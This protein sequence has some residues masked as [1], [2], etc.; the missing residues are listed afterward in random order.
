M[1]DRLFDI[2]DIKDETEACASPSLTFVDLGL[3]SGTLW[4]ATDVEEPVMVGCTLPSYQQAQELIDCC[5]FRVGTYPDGTRVMCILG[6]SGHSILFPME[7]YDGT[8]EPSGCCWCRGERDES[9]YS[10]FLLLSEGLITIGVA[11]KR[12]TFPYRMVR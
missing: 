11:R 6:P 4:A 8:P 5:E 1:K 2:S 9:D 10:Y 12:L 7:D 3:P